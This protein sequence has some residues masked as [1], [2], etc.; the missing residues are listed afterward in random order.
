M[1][2]KHNTVLV[3]TCLLVSTISIVLCMHYKVLMFHVGSVESLMT[4]DPVGP[5]VGSLRTSGY[6][7]CLLS[8]PGGCLICM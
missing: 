6:Y 4:K 8:S 1:M 5:Q 3:H 7:E 2:L